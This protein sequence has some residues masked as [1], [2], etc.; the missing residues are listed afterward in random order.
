MTQI[1]LR[2]LTP[3][4]LGLLLPWA[5]SP[6]GRQASLRLISIDDK[7]IVSS[8][9]VSYTD[10]Q[11]QV[12]SFPNE[13]STAC[14]SGEIDSVYAA[15]LISLPEQK[16]AHATHGASLKLPY[17]DLST[18]ADKTDSEG[19]LPMRNDNVSYSSLLGDPVAGLPTAD[20]SVFTMFSYHFRIQCQSL[21][22]AS[23]GTAFSSG[24]PNK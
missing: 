5:L 18:N 8:S 24:I 23:G 4:R 9:I 14:C 1:A 19:W 10:S 13:F 21:F 6:I 17:F 16:G 3:I 12:S 11:E 7:N 22:N 2:R 20:S 15:A